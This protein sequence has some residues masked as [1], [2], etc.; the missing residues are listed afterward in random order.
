M[1]LDVVTSGAIPPNPAELLQ[2]KA[3]TM[4]L[5]DL[6]GRY[7][8]VIVGAHRLPVTDAALIA[9]DSDGAILV[10]RHGKT[11]REQASQAKQR[12]DSVG[13]T[14]LGTVLNL[15][16]ERGSDS[17]GYTPGYGYSPEP[18]PTDAS[19]ATSIATE[20][21]DALDSRSQGARRSPRGGKTGRDPGVQVPLAPRC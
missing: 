7:D 10:A 1:G 11:T 15:V 9:A 12:M 21:S 18:A 5:A 13:A 17:Y 8:V 4:L 3:M 20:Q 6:R 14:L 2:S 19:A 16:P